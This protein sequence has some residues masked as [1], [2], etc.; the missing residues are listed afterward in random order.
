MA[1]GK[2][3]N[4]E[5]CRKN[6]YQPG[7][8]GKIATHHMKLYHL[9]SNMK[10]PVVVESGVEKGL[11]TCI[12]LK[13]CEKT[14]GLLF[15]VDIKDCRDV[16]QSDVW[17]F[18]QT[19]DQNI[20]RILKEAPKIS[21]GIDLLHIDSVHTREH[22]EVLLMKWY[23]YIKANGYITFHDIDETPYKF[24]RRKA[25]RLSEKNFFELSTLVKEFFYANEDELFLEYHFGSTGMGIMK[26]LSAL[27]TQPNPPVHIPSFQES[28]KESSRLLIS[29]IKRR[30]GIN[31]AG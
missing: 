14:S 21:E 20:E 7:F 1:S 25:N 30:L 27:G 11:T 9:V 31:I 8:E 4:F 28:I 16:A 5:D 2:Y 23:P 19:S 17:T 15:S 3:Y 12:F 13:A 22:V 24:G 10:Q 6:E 29:A 18:I 26:K